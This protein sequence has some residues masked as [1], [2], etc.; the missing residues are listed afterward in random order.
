M[1][2]ETVNNVFQLQKVC[3]VHGKM[4]KNKVKTNMPLVTHCTVDLCCMGH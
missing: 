4:G 2:E 3:K 1:R